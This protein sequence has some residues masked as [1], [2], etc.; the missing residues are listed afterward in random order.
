MIG[1]KKLIEIESEFCY[2][3]FWQCWLGF[4][5][6]KKFTFSTRLMNAVYQLDK[7]KKLIVV[8]IDWLSPHLTKP[9]LITWPSNSAIEILVLKSFIPTD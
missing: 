6:V 5:S 2:V 3:V 8:R 9:Y 4:N 1:V 7:R